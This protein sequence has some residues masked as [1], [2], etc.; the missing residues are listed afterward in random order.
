MCP[1]NFQI[2]KKMGSKYIEIFK[3]LFKRFIDDMKAILYKI[4]NNMTT[5]EP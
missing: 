3:M 2:I 1:K 5:L 4:Q